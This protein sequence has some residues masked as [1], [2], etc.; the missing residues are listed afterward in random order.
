MR[1]EEFFLAIQRGLTWFQEDLND[2]IC[3]LFESKCARSDG[4]IHF[5]EGRNFNEA[6][7]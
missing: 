3:G 2:R 6:A 5:E 1:I 4:S 7:R